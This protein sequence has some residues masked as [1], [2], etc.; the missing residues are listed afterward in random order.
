MKAIHSYNDHLDDLV[1][2]CNHYKESVVE[3]ILQLS[4]LT[5][6]S[7]VYALVIN[8]FRLSCFKKHETYEASNM[9]QTI[10]IMQKHNL[11]FSLIIKFYT[12][13]FSEEIFR[14]ESLSQLKTDIQVVDINWHDIDFIIEKYCKKSEVNANFVLCNEDLLFFETFNEFFKSAD[15]KMSRTSLS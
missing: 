10:N 5:C 6:S 9:K 2:F 3:A 12:E 7:S 1:M 15:V 14:V 8:K 11:E 4:L 13:Y